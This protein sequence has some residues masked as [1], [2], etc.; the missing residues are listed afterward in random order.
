MG[1][2]KDSVT[3]RNGDEKDL[4]A[5]FDLFWVSSLEHL[6]YNQDFDALKTKENC[7]DYIIN[8]QKEFMKNNNHIFLVAEDEKK[9]VGMIT[10]HVDKRDEAEIYATETMGYIT[11]LCIQ[12]DYRKNG[13]GKKLVDKL[14]QEL[15]KMQVEFVGVGVSYKNPAVDFYTSLGFSPQGVWFVRGKTGEK[16]KEKIEIKEG[17]GSNHYNPY[18]RGKATLPFKV[19]VKPESVMGDYIALH[20]LVPQNELPENL[21]R[22]IPE[23]EIWIREDI[24][25]DQKRRESI[26][27]G[28]EKF[29]LG[30]MVTK[31]LTYKQ[32]HRIAELH[33]QV[34]KIE[35]ELANMENELK[36]KPFEPVKLIDKTPE[37]KIEKKE[38]DKKTENKDESKTT[39]KNSPPDN[40]KTDIIK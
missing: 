24:Y 23:D 19:I 29:E 25:N 7:K 34:Y 30:L 26:L 20:G 36:L 10:G 40:K 16:I 12:P 31:G 37:P 22:Q 38:E 9:I 4:D 14:L 5:F 32:A 21:R 33:E 27:E 17:N 6:K 13:I 11:E 28:H 8:R 15:F 1:M 18:G 35:E 39:E 2:P 3:I